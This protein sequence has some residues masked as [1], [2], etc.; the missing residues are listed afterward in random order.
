MNLYM[1]IYKF[2]KGPIKHQ[3]HTQS[4]LQL[5]SKHQEYK[6]ISNKVSRGLHDNKHQAFYNILYSTT[7]LLY[8]YKYSIN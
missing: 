6:P 7:L 1:H 2:S 8:F 5:L 4:R 3:E